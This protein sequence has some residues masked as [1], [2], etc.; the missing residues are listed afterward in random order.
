MANFFFPQEKINKKEISE[1]KEV[2]AFNYE[3]AN[4]LEISKGSEAGAVSNTVDGFVD[5][6]GRPA[7]KMQ[8][9]GIKATI[10]VFGTC[11]ANPFFIF[12]EV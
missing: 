6:K 3:K 11:T 1:G 10:F 8:H 4:G 2:G 9:G 7:N 5:Y 12:L